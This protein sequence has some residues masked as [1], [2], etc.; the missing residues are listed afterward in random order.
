MT[1]PKDNPTHDKDVVVPVVMSSR[2]FELLTM[3]S[4][5]WATSYEDT[6][7]DQIEDGRFEVVMAEG[8]EPQA[9]WE[10]AFWVE[11]NWANVL[12][13]KS[14]LAANG[15][16][17]EVLG[18]LRDIDEGHA[19]FVI[20]SDFVPEIWREDLAKVKSD[21][22]QQF[23]VT[24]VLIDGREKAH[25]VRRQTIEAKE[26]KV[27]STFW[28]QSDETPNSARLVAWQPVTD[29]AF[30]SDQDVFQ[31]AFSFK[32]GGQFAC[33]H[34]KVS[35]LWMLGDNPDDALGAFWQKVRTD[36]A[37]VEIHEVSRVGA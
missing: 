16:G 13:A 34:P 8:E 15:Y 20:L 5:L 27:P 21:P 2:D 33:G 37:H 25:G 30:P 32:Q 18:D 29:G 3:Q 7:A 14:W 17:Y 22:V 35:H 24:Y 4:T 26:S 10:T 23:K 9:H 11:N 12:L 36:P 31:I 1:D 6:W 19:P 28:D